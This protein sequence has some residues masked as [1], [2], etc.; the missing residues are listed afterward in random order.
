MA[1]P[2]L[3]GLEMRKETYKEARERL[4]TEALTLG[5]RVQTERKSVAIRDPRLW[6]PAHEE[7]ASVMVILR[8]RGVFLRKP[9]EEAYSSG[10]DMRGLSI[11]DLRERVESFDNE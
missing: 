9:G 5:W 8:P 11:A 2:A 7:A 6:L 4:T 3:E 1:A 10:L